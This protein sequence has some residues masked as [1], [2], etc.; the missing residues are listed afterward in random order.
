M[1]PH[2]GE[3]KP[4]V[5]PPSLWPVG[6]AAGILILL[7]GI[8]V[9]LHIIVLGA[10]LTVGFGFLWVRDATAEYR[11]DVPRIEPERRPRREPA[12]P[13]LVTPSGDGASPTDGAALPL[14][15]EEEVERFPRSKFLE[16][17]TLGVGGL[18]GGMVT[19]PALG[20]AVLPAFGGQHD[21]D[22][23][24]GAID[25]FPEGRFVITTFLMNPE[26]GEVSRRTAYVRNNG[27][28]DGQPSF[29][30]VSNR[31]VHL[32]C[33]V[34][35]NGPLEEENT[36][37]EQTKT[38]MVTR[39]P[40]NPAGFGCPCHG[41]QYDVEGNRTAGPPV[42]ALDRY[43]YSIKGGRLFLGKTFSVGHVDGEGKD[44]RITRYD[45]VYPGIH[46]DGPEQL[47]Y[48]IEPPD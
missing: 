32:G 20:V 28:R 3:H 42:R 37:R 1:D 26:E 18:I 11:G 19:V 8:I 35:P 43:E 31:C 14:A 15:S 7:L 48:P 4:H 12:A 5:P 22:V 33:P 23:D 13:P 21:A 9:G 27:V 29:T 47:L 38:G 2:G 34:Q 45:R 41:G 36:E 44:A 17:A 16:A 24:V 6:F 30:I 39:I 10:I 40:S 46:V 25:D